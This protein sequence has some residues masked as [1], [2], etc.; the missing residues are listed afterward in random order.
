MRFIINNKE[1]DSLITLLI[2]FIFD[3]VFNLMQGVFILKDGFKDAFDELNL[4]KDNK[5]RVLK[6]LS[7]FGLKTPNNVPFLKSCNG[8]YVYSASLNEVR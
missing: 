6:R 5:P 3:L 8:V 4:N 2:T 1:S 7:T